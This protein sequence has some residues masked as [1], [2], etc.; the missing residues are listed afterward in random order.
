MPGSRGSGG[1]RRALSESAHPTSPYQRHDQLP[2]RLHGDRVPMYIMCHNI[3]VPPLD[4]IPL[5]DS[6]NSN[7]WNSPC[8]ASMYC[9]SCG[10]VAPCLRPYTCPLVLSSSLLLR[11]S[12]LWA[13]A[14]LLNVIHV[15]LLPPTRILMWLC[16][17]A[18]FIVHSSFDVSIGVHR[19]EN[20][21]PLQQ[22][23]ELLGMRAL[24][25]ISSGFVVR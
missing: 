2:P 1:S 8:S 6:L 15:L 16:L 17:R 7:I 11:P 21:A 14:S 18:S 13:Y 23:F 3:G 4:F 19:Y 25:R 20:G 22:G 10:A 9:G 5:R 12:T 24:A